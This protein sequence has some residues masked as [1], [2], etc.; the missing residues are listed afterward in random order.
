MVKGKRSKILVALLVVSFVIVGGTVWYFNFQ[1]PHSLAL[2][3]YNAAVAGIEVKNT[4]LDTAVNNLQ[5]L[6]DSS[7][8][9]LDDNIIVTAKEVIKNAG[10][11]KKLVGEV[12]KKTEDI[13]AKT[14]E[15]SIPVDY[16]NII[17]ELNDT[18]AALDAN[19]KQ[20]KQL[21]NPAEEFVIQRLQTIDEVLEVR[22]VT[23]DNDPNG[24]LNKAGGYTATV[25]FESKNINQN[26]VYGTDLIDKGTDAGGAVE[27]YASEEDAIKRNDY[28]A[29]FDGSIFSSGSHKVAGTVVIRTSDELTASQQ[30]ALE[31]KVLDALKEL[32]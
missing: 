30:Q 21:T 25:Y 27:V 8:K 17:R 5:A 6:I 32:R 16:S 9:P 11:T 24:K 23:E 12:P 2:K 19:I 4:E 3:E 1:R 15:L 7:E 28:L 10:A 26:N 14:Q 13:I 18:Y 20:F 22:A 29:A 31:Q